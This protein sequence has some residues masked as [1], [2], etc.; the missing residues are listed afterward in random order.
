NSQSSLVLLDGT[1]NPIILVGEDD[2]D[3]LEDFT[4]QTLEKSKE[5]VSR[6]G[7]DFIVW[8]TSAD[9]NWTLIETTSWRELTEGSIY[10]TKLLIL[11]GIALL[12]AGLTVVLFVSRQFTKPISIL[13]RA[14][15]QYSLKG[16]SAIPEDYRNEFGGLFQWFQKLVTRIEEL[17]VSLE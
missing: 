12:L 2:T 8:S 17:Y 5:G 11:A 3:K 13:L 9:S 15:N 16:H 4:K 1:G 7:D 6:Q 14:M 10:L